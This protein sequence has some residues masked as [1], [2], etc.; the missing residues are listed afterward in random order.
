MFNVK[1]PVQCKQ[2]SDVKIHIP[3]SCHKQETLPYRPKLFLYQLVYFCFKVVHF[4]TAVYRKWCSFGNQ[5]QV[6]IQGEQSFILRVQRLLLG[7]YFYCTCTQ[8][9]DTA[10]V[11]AHQHHWCFQVRLLQN[12]RVAV[13]GKEWVMYYTRATSGVAKFS[14]RFLVRFLLTLSL[15]MSAVLWVKH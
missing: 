6:A 7:C 15:L 13:W 11:S 12:W 9:H 8:H 5:P 1:P 10:L 3:Y 14:H 4:K 2:V